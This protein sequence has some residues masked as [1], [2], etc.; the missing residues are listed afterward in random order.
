V[1]VA[2]VVAVDEAKAAKIAKAQ[3]SHSL[4]FVAA[5]LFRSD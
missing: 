2:V 4:L 1:F 5:H 3:V